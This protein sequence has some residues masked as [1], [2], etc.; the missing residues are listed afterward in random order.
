MPGN[1][2]EYPCQGDRERAAEVVDGVGDDG[3][4]VGNPPADEGYDRKGQID[5][6]GREDIAACALAMMMYML[7]CH[8]TLFS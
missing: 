6:K 3:H 2:L 8:A 5:E 4:A 7:M 1:T